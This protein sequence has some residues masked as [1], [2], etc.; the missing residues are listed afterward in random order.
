MGV[1][2]RKFD[3]SKDIGGI[4]R[5]LSESYE[6]MNRDGNWI[7]PMWDYSC[8]HPL[9][10]EEALAK[11]GVW[12]NGNEIVAAAIFDLHKTDI[13]LCTGAQYRH[14]KSD[15]VKYA[16]DH[17]SAEKEGSRFLNIYAHDF[18]TDLEDTLSRAGYL[19]KPE[20]DQILSFLRIPSPFPDISLPEGLCAQKSG[21]T[22]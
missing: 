22:Q 11:V 9:T 7:Q 6:P 4:S 16:E 19:R 2:L 3:A 5:F 15:M 17:L 13:S 10:E 18:D 12:K 8:F 1:T 14:L 21:R 20:A